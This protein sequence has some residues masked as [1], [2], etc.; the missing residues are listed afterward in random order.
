MDHTKNNTPFIVIMGPTGSGKSAL[1][2]EVAK[3]LPCEII[4]ADSMQ[5]YR[6]MDIG[7]A[8]PTKAEQNAVKHHLIDILEI[9]QRLDVYFYVEKAKIAIKKIHKNRKIPLIVG[10]S[11]MY[12]RSL[13]YGLD[14]LPSSAKL[15]EKLGS[16]YDRDDGL[17]RLIEELTELDSKATEVLGE[18][19]RKLLRAMEV[20]K[21]T[22]KSI[23]QQHETWQENKLCSPV[24]AYYV[25][26][27]RID[28]F[29]R[30]KKRADKMLADGWIEETDSL[31]KKGLFN[32]PTARQ[33]I[34]YEI[35]SKYLSNEINY[36]DM[37][38]RIIAATKRYA[39]RQET[40]FDNQHPEAK[41]V[42]MPTRLK[43]LADDIVN[44]YVMKY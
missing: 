35:I 4:S 11:G 42:L 25:S 2:L 8:K 15:R 38:T 14:P 19:K 30:I 20:F 33:A 23:T 40:W 41:K 27:D 17:K 31:A 26:R 7:T 39:R 34:G 28:L 5:V 3:K 1:A 37:K 22:G 9:Q 36:E 10:G 13:L 21:L 32:T 29:D 12:I 18:N 16:K 6:G 44:K 43:N 24:F